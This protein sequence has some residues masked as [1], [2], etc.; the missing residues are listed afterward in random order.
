LYHYEKDKPSFVQSNADFVA[1]ILSFLVLSGSW[2]WE[3]RRWL[4][5]TQKNNA[6]AFRTQIVGLIN[7]ARVAESA[8][9]LSAIREELMRILS[10][11]VVD[12][13]EDRINEQS[14]QSMR[15]VW[16]IALDAV[17][18]RLSILERPADLT[19]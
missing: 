9:E 14:F 4:Q 15:A 19:R 12:L 11:S 1:L 17:R 8:K 18:E 10:V 13:D 6:D 7:Q 16:E 5:R 3:L 2:L